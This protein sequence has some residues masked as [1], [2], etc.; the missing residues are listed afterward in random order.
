MS[1]LTGVNLAILFA[2]HD[3][4]KGASSSHQE[5]CFARTFITGNQFVARRADLAQDNSIQRRAIGIYDCYEDQMVTPGIFATLVLLWRQ[6]TLFYNLKVHR[7]G[8]RVGGWGGGRRVGGG[9]HGGVGRR[10]R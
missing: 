10:W 3:E 1:G 6:D 4:C 2:N 5:L 9:R 8:R 7:W